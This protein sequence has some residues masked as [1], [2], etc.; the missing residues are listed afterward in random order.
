MIEVETRVTHAMVRPANAPPSNTSTTAVPR[1]THRL[2]SSA[3]FGS[4]SSKVVNDDSVG[5]AWA[6]KAPIIVMSSTRCRRLKTGRGDG[7]IDVLRPWTGRK[8]LLAMTDV[9][10]KEW[11]ENGAAEVTRSRVSSVERT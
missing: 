3:G 1:Y 4:T 6:W 11:R 9:P 7:A 5:K 2:G 10:E 8:E